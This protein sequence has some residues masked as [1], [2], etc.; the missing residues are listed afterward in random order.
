MYNGELVNMTDIL[1]VYLHIRSKMRNSQELHGFFYHGWMHTKSFFDAICYLAV[2]ENVST[3]D[4]E[5]LKIAALYH[6]TGYTTGK[7]EDHEYKSTG[8]ACQELPLFGVEE[9]GVGHICRLIMS[10]APGYRS[11]GILEEIMHDAD[12]EYLGRDYYPHVAE[13][14][15]KEKCIPDYIWKAEQIS[16][17]KGHKFLTS[18]ARLLFDNQK[19]INYRKLLNDS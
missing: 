16:F 19:D 2:L 7:S 13:L 3:E 12:C 18:S 15:R 8:I 5:K 6:D 9:C 1:K 14:L 11:S 10:T 4:L 17:L